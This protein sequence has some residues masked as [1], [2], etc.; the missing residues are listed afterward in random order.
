MEMPRR[1]PTVLIADDHPIVVDGLVA[2][3]KD[4]FDV[5]GTVSDPAIPNS[6]GLSSVFGATSGVLS[7][8]GPPSTR[9]RV[10]KNVAAVSGT[11]GVVAF[12][13]LIDEQFEIWTG[14]IAT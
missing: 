12:V 8:T 14:G 1:R 10:Y 7:C 6:E 13:I 5:V 9:L 3:L 11:A 4:R 2:L